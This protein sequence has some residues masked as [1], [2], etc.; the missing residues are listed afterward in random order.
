MDNSSDSEDVIT[1][2]TSQLAGALEV[3][4][5]YGVQTQEVPRIGFE[6]ATSV[7]LLLMGSA[8]AVHTVIYILEQRKG[9]QVV[10]LRKDAAKRVYRTPDVVFGTV[11]ILAEDGGVEVVVREP[12]GLFGQVAS[13][14]AALASSGESP[15]IANLMNVVTREFGDSVRVRSLPPAAVASLEEPPVGDEQKES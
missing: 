1:L 8:A 11:V 7:T 9:G 3:A 5:E 10:N 13:S 14:V 12:K 4:S 2:D 6:P 15:Q